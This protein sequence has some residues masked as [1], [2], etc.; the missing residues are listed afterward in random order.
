MANR[1][2]NPRRAKSLHTYTIA[3]A[4]ELYEVH[5]NTVRHWLGDGLKPLDGRKP[6][7]LH[8]TALNGY[9]AARRSLSKRPCGPDKLYCMTCRAPRR[10]A[11]GMADYTPLTTS[12]GA[13]VAICGDCGG[14][15]TQRVNAARLK[16]FST[17][18][19]VT[20]RPA[21]EPIKESV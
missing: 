12:V 9:H 10:P 19:E 17:E 11:L 3:E 15:M 6:V 16:L 4:A 21:P 18:I 5:R 1:R 8:G 13:L 20:I 14:V 2:H 7:L